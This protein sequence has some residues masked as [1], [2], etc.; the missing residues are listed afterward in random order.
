M[1]FQ[2]KD[3]KVFL[4]R[5]LSELDIFLLDFIEILQERT[6]PYVIVSGYVSILFGRARTTEDIDIFVGDVDKE[7]FT[8]FVDNIERRDFWIINTTSTSEAFDMLNTEAIRIARQ[9]TA[10]PNIELKRATDEDRD[11]LTDNLVVLL[12]G[13]PL[14][15]SRL[16][17]QIPYKF[18]LES[19][20]D[21]EDAVYLF[22]LFKEHIDKAFL[23]RWARTLHVE[24]KVMQYV[25]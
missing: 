1:S 15:V 11:Q 13:K 25:G 21:I 12:N 2:F 23:M 6:I 5:K 20:K 14:H 8:A 9:Q 22:E 10:I 7:T 16:E 4:E 17:V 19:D 24:S 18:Y 3:G